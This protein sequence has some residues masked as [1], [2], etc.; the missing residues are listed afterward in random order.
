[1]IS[2]PNYSLVKPDKVLGTPAKPATHLFFRRV[3]PLL[4]RHLEKAERENGF[5][6]HQKVPD[7]CPSLEEKATFGLAQ[8]EPFSLP[9]PSPVRR[10][11]FSKICNFHS[12]FL[13]S[14]LV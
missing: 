5:I 13:C 2:L 12:L 7:D 1:M 3:E 6:Y 14:G 9:S 4:K 11:T 10:E 8:P